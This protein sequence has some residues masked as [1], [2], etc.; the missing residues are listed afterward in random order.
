MPK[1]RRLLL[2]L[3]HADWLGAVVSVVRGGRVQTSPDALVDR[4]HDCSEVTLE[5]D[6]DLDDKSHLGTAFWILALPG[7]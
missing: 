6:L 5:S 4:M 7:A 2:S 3:E 1:R